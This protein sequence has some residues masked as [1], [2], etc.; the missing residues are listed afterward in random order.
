MY[1][2]K[3]PFCI[4]SKIN[5]EYVRIPT[6]V[7]IVHIIQITTNIRLYVVLR[8]QN[9]H[10]PHIKQSLLLQYLS[11][12]QQSKLAESWIGLST[13]TGKFYRCW[14]GSGFSVT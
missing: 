6:R 10:N 5:E 3:S 1:K 13:D 4:F 12:I 9:P 14:G 2:E 8:K 11:L 7:T